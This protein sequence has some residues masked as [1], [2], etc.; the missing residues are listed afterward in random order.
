MELPDTH[1][2]ALKTLA[3][4]HVDAGQITPDFLDDLRSWGMVTTH[5]LEPAPGLARVKDPGFGRIT[6]RRPLEC[7]QGAR[8][9]RAREQ[10][11]GL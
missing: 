9:P 8:I 4:G 3:G 1:L 5:S 11:V 6:S 2:E 10:G 7:A